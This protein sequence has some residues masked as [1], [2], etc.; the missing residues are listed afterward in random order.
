MW[1]DLRQEAAELAYRLDDLPDLD[2]DELAAAQA[3]W[4]GRMVNE[5]V[6]SRVFAA[7]IPQ[8]MRANVRPARQAEVAAMIG[9]ELRHARSCAG[10]LAALGGEARATLPK[11]D[12]VPS[13]EDAAPVEAV[14][15][16]VMSICCLSETVAVS[17]IS[18]EYFELEGSQIGDVLK[19]ILADEVRH[20]RFGWE[21]LTELLP[22]IDEDTRA[23]LNAYLE[24]AL[25]HLHDHELAHLP[26]CSQMSDNVARAGVC[27]GAE[28]RKLFFETVE[29]VIV[30]GLEERGLAGRRA[31]RSTAKVSAARRATGAIAFA[32]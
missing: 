32:A 16:N 27:D 4:R 14:L 26:A 15:R 5:H 24:V 30:P 21:L 1:L 17:L 8:M 2:E 23:R 9:E 13:H 28:A 29:N 20:A 3:T 11:L 10:V 22:T 25:R 7:L 18:A 31:W 12:D 6:S 19:H